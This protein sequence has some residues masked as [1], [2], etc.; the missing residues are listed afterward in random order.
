MTSNT[1][2]TTS[3]VVTHFAHSFSSRNSSNPKKFPIGCSGAKANTRVRIL[4]YKQP[5]KRMK[6]CKKTV[7]EIVCI[8]V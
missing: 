6:D 3:H 2:N 1:I 8:I 4:T 5:F 7:S